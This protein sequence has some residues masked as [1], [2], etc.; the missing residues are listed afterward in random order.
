LAVRRR[1]GGSWE[2]RRE[3]G[4]GGGSREKEKEKGGGGT[5]RCTCVLA[6]LLATKYVGSS[7]ISPP[8]A[9]RGR[10]GREEVESREGGRREGEGREKGAG[11][12]SREER[13]GIP[14]SSLCRF[15]Q[16]MLV[17][18]AFLLHQPLQE[19]GKKGGE[20]GEGGEG[21]RRE[22]EGW[23]RVEKG[24]RGDVP[25][26]SLG[27]LPQRILVPVAFLLHQPLQ[28]FQISGTSGI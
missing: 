3:E 6:L 11:E 20:G 19:G 18:V 25:V 1:E 9:T 8:P 10:R 5:G 23:R 2:R 13:E 26:S 17:P 28:K 12:G 7:R 22:E 4:E 24:G 27:S 15:P 16:S 14:L 21:E